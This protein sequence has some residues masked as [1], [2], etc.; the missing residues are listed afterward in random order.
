[1]EN[2]YNTILKYFPPKETVELTITLIE[3]NIEIISN[4]F[5]D[6]KNKIIDDLNKLKNEKTLQNNENQ[7]IAIQLISNKKKNST[8]YFRY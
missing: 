4:Y 7:K 8:L 3:E 5:K 2:I 1:M 6:I